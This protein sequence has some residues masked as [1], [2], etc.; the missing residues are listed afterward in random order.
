MTLKIDCRHGWSVQ[1]FTEKVRELRG[2][3]KSL[4]G[5]LRA[6]EDAAKDKKCNCYFRIDHGPEGGYQIVA[7][8]L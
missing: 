2:S 8:F 7:V 5:F 4:D 1:E 3:D 6:C